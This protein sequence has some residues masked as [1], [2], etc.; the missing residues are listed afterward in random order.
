MF[1]PEWHFHTKNFLIRWSIAPDYDLDLS[2]DETGEVRA[3]LE[4]DEYVAFISKMEVIHKPTGNVIGEDYLHGSIYE[5]PRDFR[6]H[7]GNRHGSYFSDMV[8]SAVHEARGTIARIQ[9]I[10]LR[11]D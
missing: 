5:N 7:I 3:K 8:R 10:N 2:W 6:D 9:A 11:G 4:S 1:D